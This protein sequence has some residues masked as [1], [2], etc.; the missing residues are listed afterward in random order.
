MHEPVH[1]CALFC[2]LTSAWA[3]KSGTQAKPRSDD[4][5]YIGQTTRVQHITD[6]TSP[7]HHRQHESNTSQTTRVQHITDRIRAKQTQI[8]LRYVRESLRIRMF[9]H[10][11][12][13]GSRLGR[14]SSPLMSPTDE[15]KRKN[16]LAEDKYV[17]NSI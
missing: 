17:C 3:A 9:L 6:N 12:M 13:C 1:P 15:D 2:C 16:T 8:L 4:R 7:T 11:M 10:L 5:Q 14:S